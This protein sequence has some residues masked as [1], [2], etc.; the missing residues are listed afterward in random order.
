MRWLFVLLA[1]LLWQGPARAQTP[2][3]VALVLAVDTSASVNYEEF[4]LQMRG[5]ASAFRDPA[6]ISAMAAAGAD[7]VAVCVMQWSGGV[8]ST[9]AVPWRHLTD[10]AD[11][12]AF[13]DLVDGAGRLPQS[14]G[15][16][17]GPAIRDAARLLHSMPYKARRRVIDVSG[18]G[19]ANQ[20]IIPE[21]ERDAAGSAGIVINGLA[22]LN[23]ER[24]L[25]HYYREKVITGPGSFVI[26]A[27]DYEDFARAMRLKLIREFGGTAISMR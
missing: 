18:D 2:V 9:L 24:Q 12:A 27:S 13:A 22:I 7:G 3:D 11:A 6:V 20:G 25:D 16:A 5:I 10:E 26:V 19:H 8:D 1:A 17:L 21:V 15:T 23:E 4:T 14:S